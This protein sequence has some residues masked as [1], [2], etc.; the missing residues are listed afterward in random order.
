[1]GKD[2]GLVARDSARVVL[3]ILEEK[4]NSTNYPSN[5]Q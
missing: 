4:K 1:M 3:K 5:Q 2:D